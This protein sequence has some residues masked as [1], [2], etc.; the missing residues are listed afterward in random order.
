M[1]RADVVRLGAPIRGAAVSPRGGT[2]RPLGPESPS[3]ASHAGRAHGRTGS[4]DACRDPPCGEVCQPTR[5]WPVPAR[6]HSPFRLA[7][8][9]VLGLVGTKVIQPAA[10]GLL[11]VVVL[12]I[13]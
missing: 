13:R 2:R 4:D 6:S 3:A 1:A 8:L 10:G 7:A 9:L 11:F 5:S 12:I